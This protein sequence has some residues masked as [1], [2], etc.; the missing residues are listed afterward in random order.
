MTKINLGD[1]V[2]DMVTG[3]T[4]IAIGRTEWLNG[5][6]RITVQPEKLKDGKIVETGCFDEPQLV[7][8]KK[9]QI[10]VGNRDT[11]GPIPKQSRAP[12]V[13]R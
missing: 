1:R 12:D 2:K 6:T 9:D 11:G 4:G 3:F 7:V 13:T 10:P 5:C 8:V